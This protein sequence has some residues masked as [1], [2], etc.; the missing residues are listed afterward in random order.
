MDSHE[1]FSQYRSIIERFASQSLCSY[2]T[3]LARLIHIATLRDVYSGVY[4][5]PLL[6]ETFPRISV[7]YALTYCHDE[8]FAKFLENTF[9]RQRQDLRACISEMESPAPEIANRWLDVE[10]FRSFVPCGAPQ[11]L[12]D[13]FL[14]NMRAALQGI[15]AEHDPVS[16]SV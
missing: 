9:E 2:S 6:E 8:I 13:L 12:K 3:D 15:A 14:W 5:H 11:Y 10:L 16:T 1:R 4:R 7:H